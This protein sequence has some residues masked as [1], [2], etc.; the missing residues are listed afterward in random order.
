MFPI[1][2]PVGTQ[3]AKRFIY[4][5]ELADGIEPINGVENCNMKGNGK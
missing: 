5:T 4:T 1:V 3:Q 2:S